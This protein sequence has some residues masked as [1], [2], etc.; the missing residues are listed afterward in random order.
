[1]IKFDSSEIIESHKYNQEEISQ[2]IYSIE[3]YFD[4]KSI[5][6]SATD[7]LGEIAPQGHEEAIRAL[8]YA[9]EN[10]IE[11]KVR[12]D[13]FE[14]LLKIT[15]KGHIST[16]K[17]FLNI[18]KNK[19]YLARESTIF[20]KEITTKIEMP[21]LVNNLKDCINYQR[22]FEPYKIYI[23]DIIWHCA[24]NLPYPEFYQAWHHP[25]TTPHPEVPDQTPVGNNSTVEN[26]EN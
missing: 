24:A 7:K 2:L 23:C 21:T 15:P 19:H 26:L 20:L 25:P 10:S 17:I 12:I 5:A 13:A 16:I 4:N 18:I 14:S 1:M 6:R 3:T 8:I 22:E 11:W 9:I